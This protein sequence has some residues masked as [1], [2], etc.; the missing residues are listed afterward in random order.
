MTVVESDCKAAAVRRMGW[1]R[2]YCLKDLENVSIN[3]SAE[4]ASSKARDRY[5]EP[6]RRSRKG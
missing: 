5:K 1:C 6:R 4:P 2:V 3:R